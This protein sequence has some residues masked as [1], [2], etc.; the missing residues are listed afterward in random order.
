LHLKIKG[1]QKD[2]SPPCPS[3][4]AE[5]QWHF[6]KNEFDFV[7]LSNTRLLCRLQHPNFSEKYLLKGITLL[8][9]HE[10]ILS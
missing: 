1:E 2:F 3:H 8:H 7:V 4:L 10:E 6:K 9:D 5:L